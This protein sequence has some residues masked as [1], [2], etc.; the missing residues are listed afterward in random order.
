M[1]GLK[2]CQDTSWKGGLKGFLHTSPK[3]QFSLH[4]H[5]DALD[6]SRLWRR[7]LKSFHTHVQNRSWKIKFNT[8][9][10]CKRS[11]KRTKYCDEG[12]VL[13]LW[14]VWQYLKVCWVGG[15]S[16]HISKIALFST[17]SRRHFWISPPRKCSFFETSPSW[18]VT[19]TSFQQF[20]YRSPKGRRRKFIKRG[21]N[22]QRARPRMRFSFF[23]RLLLIRMSS[24]RYCSVC[25]HHL[26]G[27]VFRAGFGI[28]RATPFDPS[29]GAPRN[30]HCMHV[31]EAS[32]GSVRD[33]Y[34]AQTLTVSWCHRV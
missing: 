29:A 12:L 18:T 24:R 13:V 25:F 7:G 19:V 4:F 5:E 22:V 32:S 21:R 11:F 28:D 30:L 26:G 1:K 27:D 10:V 16:S 20:Q 23:P 31:G 33:V 34:G 3:F 15:F 14:F 6:I 2:M 17:F 8:N 9:L